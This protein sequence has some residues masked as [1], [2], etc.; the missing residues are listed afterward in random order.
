MSISKT[1]T[2]IL[3]LGAILI[4]AA[5]SKPEPVQSVVFNNGR[6]NMAISDQWVLQRD[7]GKKAFWRHGVAENVKLSF[8]D[9]TADYGTP[10]TVMGVRSAVGT[11]LNRL[12]GGIVSGRLGYGGAAI[13]TYEKKVK[14]GSKDVFSKN[15]VVAG[16]LGW[17]AVAR[18]AIT[19]K[20]PHG[21]QSTPEL[22]ALIESLD[23]QVGDAKLPEA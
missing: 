21:Q 6:L 14:E 12:H 18:V 17:G 22:Q 15:W 19:L 2:L 23:K 16:P 11:E 3:A 5:C 4:A 10:M 1:R 13:L 7:G 20:A 9:Q 8:E